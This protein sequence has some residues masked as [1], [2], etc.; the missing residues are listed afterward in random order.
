[1]SKHQRVH[2]GEK[3]FICPVCGRGF[4]RPSNCLSHQRVHM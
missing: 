2:S 4:N 3:P 1:L